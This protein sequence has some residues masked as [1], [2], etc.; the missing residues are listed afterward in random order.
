VGDGEIVFELKKVEYGSWNNLEANL[1]KEEQRE[2]RKK[3]LERV[4]ENAKAEQ[5]RKHGM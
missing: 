1:S 5:E 2:M 4:Q 3:I